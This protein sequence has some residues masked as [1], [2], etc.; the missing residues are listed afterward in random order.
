MVEF[1][2]FFP[3]SLQLVDSLREHLAHA[4]LVELPRVHFDVACEMSSTLQSCDLDRT[5]M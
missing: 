4:W 2:V 3:S 5:R 1:I